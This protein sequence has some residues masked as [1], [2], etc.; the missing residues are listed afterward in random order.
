MMELNKSHVKYFK[1]YYR[2]AIIARMYDLPFRKELKKYKNEFI[3]YFKEYN[4][5]S[6]EDIKYE[7]LMKVLNI[8][9]KNIKIASVL[10]FYKFETYFQKT[11]TEIEKS[12]SPKIF[13][14]SRSKV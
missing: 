10:G 8:Y 4:L 2:R 7:N 3:K 13:R 5:S 6:L 1:K 9:K 11:I 14:K 12:N